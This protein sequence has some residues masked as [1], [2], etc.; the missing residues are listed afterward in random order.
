MHTE[1]KQLAY[2]TNDFDRAVAELRHIHHMGPFRELRHLHMPTRESLTAEA[3]F[4]LAFKAGLQ[5]EVIQPLAGDTSIYSS[6]LGDTSEFV[7]RFHHIGH[8]L[9]DEKDYQRHLSILNSRWRLPINVSA[10]GG[11][12]AYADARATLGHFIEIFSFPVGSEAI[13]APHY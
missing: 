3:H 9:S 7:L 2:V 6:L 12:Y 1:F 8:Y 10:F 4:G 13:A 11:C 5:Y